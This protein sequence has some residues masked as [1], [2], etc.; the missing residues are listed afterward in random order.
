MR[1]LNARKETPL[2]EAVR[3]G[4]KHM[5]ELLMAADP[6]LAIFPKEGPSPLYLAITLQ[7]IDIAKSL[8]V[9]S[10]GNLSYSGPNGQNAL[11]AAVLRGQGTDKL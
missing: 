11:H 1:K 3:L 4:S 8:Y 2:H 9:M 6:E 5:V 10:A 7:R